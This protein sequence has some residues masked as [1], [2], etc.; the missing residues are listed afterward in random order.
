MPI[1]QS[2]LTKIHLEFQRFS[3]GLIYMSGQKT[4]KEEKILWNLWGTDIRGLET[5]D[6][7]L[8]KIKNKNAKKILSMID[9]LI[10]DHNDDTVTVYYI[11]KNRTGFTRDRRENDTQV[12]III[13]FEHNEHAHADD[14]F[15]IGTIMKE[16]DFWGEC[17]LAFMNGWSEDLY[18]EMYDVDA[19]IH[20]DSFLMGDVPKYWI[21]PQHKMTDEEQQAE[22]DR[23]GGIQ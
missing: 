22:M 2:D 11:L 9:I 19:S 10:P 8:D 18:I 20:G 17:H 1:M 16:L 5:I 21:P 23:I 12:D 3:G 14:L 7:T 6:K 15:K 13:G 4:E